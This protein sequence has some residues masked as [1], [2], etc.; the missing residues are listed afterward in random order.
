MRRLFCLQR[1]VA[2][3]VCRGIW[4]AAGNNNSSR[5]AKQDVTGRVVGMCGLQGALMFSQLCY[6]S[7]ALPMFE[8]M[9]MHFPSQMW[10][11]MFV[12]RVYCKLPSVTPTFLCSTSFHLLS[13]QQRMHGMAAHSWLPT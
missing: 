9:N 10:A 1:T 3:K 13:L 12:V 11:S 7:P 8:E 2:D 6:P 5:H 4:T